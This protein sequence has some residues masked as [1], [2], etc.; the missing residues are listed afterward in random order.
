MIQNVPQERNGS[1]EVQKL[2]RR[3]G[4]VIRSLVLHDMVNRR[5]VSVVL[6]RHRPLITSFDHVVKVSFLRVQVI[7]EMATAAMALSV[8]KRFRA[9]PCIIQNNPLVFSRKADLKTSPQSKVASAPPQPTEVSRPPPRF[10]FFFFFI[11][12]F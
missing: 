2:V 6:P 12:F 8:F 3:F 9:F 4:T 1:S 11:T 7:C 10:F 5:F